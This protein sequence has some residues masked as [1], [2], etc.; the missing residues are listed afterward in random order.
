MRAIAAGLL[1]V[2][3]GC[4]GMHLGPP[5]PTAEELAEQ[6]AALPYAELVAPLCQD[7][8][9]TPGMTATADFRERCGLV[10]SAMGPQDF[11]AYSA[12][13]C[14]SKERGAC[15]DGYVGMYA[16]RVL[17]RYPLTNLD[18][19]DIH[20]TAHP[21]ECTTPTLVELQYLGSHNRGVVAERQAQAAASAERQLASRRATA[22]AVG[23]AF[24]Q[25]GASM[26]QAYRQPV[27]C[28]SRAS[29]GTVRT[30][31]Y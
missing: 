27:H 15:W 7:G 1:L 3:G 8:S 12:R 14:R 30:D 13:H 11:A 31:C 6:V 25:M 29:V 18:A 20:C 23:A 2:L 16:A 22:Q 28:T 9:T 10:S 24:Q 5:L 4:A 17:E 21:D 26:Q 19:V